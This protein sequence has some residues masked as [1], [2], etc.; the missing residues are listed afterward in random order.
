MQDTRRQGDLSRGGS[1]RDEHGARGDRRRAQGVHVHAHA[2]FRTAQADW[3][4]QTFRQ[5]QVRRRRV[6]G[7]FS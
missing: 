2:A 6:L 3:R 7:E 1:V 4:I 5:E